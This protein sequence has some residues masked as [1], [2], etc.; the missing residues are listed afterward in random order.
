MIG[1]VSGA[2]VDPSLQPVLPVPTLK[3]VGTGQDRFWGTDGL[4]LVVPKD[5]FIRTGRDRLEEGR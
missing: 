4:S 2:A 3:G 5:R 1:H